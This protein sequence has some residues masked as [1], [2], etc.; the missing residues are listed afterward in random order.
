[1]QLK[2][3]KG[4]F[5]DPAVSPINDLLN[6]KPYAR[7]PGLPKTYYP[8][9]DASIAGYAVARNIRH[10]TDRSGVHYPEP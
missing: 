8:S 2:P 9:F 6:F 3:F 10:G 7:Q 5:K 1:M 4:R